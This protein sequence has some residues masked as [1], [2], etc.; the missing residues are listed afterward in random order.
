MVL[1]QKTLGQRIVELSH[2]AVAMHL[3]A[4]LNDDR[5]AQEERRSFP[6]EVRRR[7]MIGGT[8]PQQVKEDRVVGG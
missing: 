7:W 5:A 3:A 8:G 2:L 6:T 4:A 1:G